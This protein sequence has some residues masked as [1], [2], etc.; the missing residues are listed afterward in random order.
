MGR[1]RLGDAV[2][3]VRPPPY[4]AGSA[5]PGPLAAVPVM[6]RSGS[7]G[8]CDWHGYLSD[9]YLAMH[10]NFR[11]STKAPDVAVISMLYWA[12]CAMVAVVPLGMVPS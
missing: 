11:N 5:H 9:L 2:G 1:Q 10:A 8:L 6:A 12:F 4:V 7:G 3:L